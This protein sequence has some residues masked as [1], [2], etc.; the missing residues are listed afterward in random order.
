[1]AAV[2]AHSKV[3]K[4]M[5]KADLARKT[6]WN[7]TPLSKQKLQVWCQKMHTSKDGR[8]TVLQWM[9]DDSDKGEF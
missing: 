5:K 4:V 8:K 2:V 9:N 3:Y 1:M 7:T 6:E